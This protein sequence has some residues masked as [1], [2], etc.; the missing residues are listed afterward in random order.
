MEK[1]G[2]VQ[3]KKSR[4]PANGGK[5]Q[6][7]DKRGVRSPPSNERKAEKKSSIAAKDPS[8]GQKEKR[9]EVKTLQHKRIELHR[10]YGEEVE[11]GQKRKKAWWGKRR[12]ESSI[13][14]RGTRKKEV[15]RP[16][17]VKKGSEKPGG[18][19]VQ[20]A[21]K[22]NGL[23]KKNREREKG[24]NGETQRKESRIGK[25]ARHGKRPSKE[26]RDLRKGDRKKI[27]RKGAGVSAHRRREKLSP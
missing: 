6:S 9:N 14:T 11:G 2:Y 23:L 12:P 4:S 26:D 15:P 20:G 22:K 3:G 18:K 19:R 24:K 8:T 10:K 27:F 17:G 21:K 1:G 25:K 13:Q 5:G 16:P 7:R